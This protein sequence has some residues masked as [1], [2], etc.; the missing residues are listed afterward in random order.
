[1]NKPPFN[2]SQPFEEVDSKPPFDP[3][4]P[5]EPSESESGLLSRIGSGAVQDVKD[6]GNV[7]GRIST[8][9][10]DLPS[11]IYKSG[12][13]IISGGNLSDTPIAQDARTV[14]G[15]V[16]NAVPHGTIQDGKYRIEPGSIYR[17]YEE[18]A[19]QPFKA[20]PGRI[21]E[22]FKKSYPGNPLV[23][24][25]VN[26][27]LALAPFVRPILRSAPVSRAI[28][29]VRES[30]AAPVQRTA[31]M[32]GRRA[33]GI[34]KSQ[35]NKLETQL[36]RANEAAQTALDTGVIRNPILRPFSSSADDMMKRAQEIDSGAG[37]QIGRF[38]KSRNEKFDWGKTLDD[39]DRLKREYPADP[40][41]I[42]RIDNAK[43]MIRR[44][45]IRN[46]GEI[47]FEEA[48][49]IKS[50]IQKKINWNS[51]KASAEIGQRTAGTVRSS[52][53]NQLETVSGSGPEFQNFKANKKLFGDSQ[54]MQ[55]GLLNKT[56]A[57][58]GN[59]PISGYP[60]LIG[61]GEGI[62]QGS[63]IRGIV[64]SLAGEWVKRYGSATAATMADAAAKFIKGN[65][66]KYNSII[67]QSI[68]TGAPFLPAIETAIDESQQII[69]FSP[70]KRRILK[71][72]SAEVP[73]I[74]ES[75]K[76]EAKVLDDEKK[77]REYLKRAD[78][79]KVKARQL[80]MSEGW[81]LNE[82]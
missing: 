2:P 37:Q 71:N 53:D 64:T 60:A 59:L 31:Q 43:D 8:G 14:Y 4:K 30:V 49:K 44:T 29:S 63:V 15:S 35:L 72:R 80:A 74:Q 75:A 24:H 11:D 32:F 22:E 68:S 45:A 19:A 6:I 9:I 10:G 62:R 26:S 79:N 20:I 3:S 1:M 58:S 23:E 27:A 34:P 82:A 51:D 73:Q 41:V 16:I 21:G 65:P 50:Y 56:A 67:R 25:P 70:P 76:P 48:N 28:E 40:E 52:L 77:A 18:L 54:I 39:L 42:N 47:P 13:Q 5:F 7:L 17:Q 12:K 81:V 36:P 38:L 78:G 57:E 61:I 69:P 33:L 66:G 55:K 46:G